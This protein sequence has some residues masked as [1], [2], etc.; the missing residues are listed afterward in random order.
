MIKTKTTCLQGVCMSYE[1][2]DRA[3]ENPHRYRYKVTQ[4]PFELDTWRLREEIAL[5]DLYGEREIEHE[6]FT[7]RSNGMV[8]LKVGYA[9]NGANFPAYNDEQNVI[10]S[11]IHD[12]ICQ[13]TDLGLIPYSDRKVGDI[14]F[15]DIMLLKAKNPYQ[16]LRAYYSYAA[17][18]SYRIGKGIF[19]KPKQRNT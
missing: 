5:L 4:Q 18:A 1:H 10:A 9:Y 6:F 13:A 14:I 15:R 3:K 12:V 2:D 7:I 19:N 16:K 17:V 11:G 8:W